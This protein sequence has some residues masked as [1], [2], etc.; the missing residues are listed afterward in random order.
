MTA[1]YDEF[2]P[3]IEF[4]EDWSAPT[5]L[6]ERAGRHPDRTYLVVPWAGESYTYGQVFDLAEKIGSAMLGPDVV[7]GDRVLIMLPNCARR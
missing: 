6:R 1:H 4:R 7:T 5:V 3:A 2:R